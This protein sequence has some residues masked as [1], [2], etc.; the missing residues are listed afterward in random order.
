V[1]ASGLP[2]LHRYA[3][4]TSASTS[5]LPTGEAARVHLNEAWTDA[6]DAVESCV[7]THQ[8]TASVL[9]VRCALRLT[10]DCVDSAALVVPT[11]TTSGDVTPRAEAD[12]SD[13]DLDTTLIGTALTCVR[14][15]VRDVTAGACVAVSCVR[16]AKVLS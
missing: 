3:T 6:L 2:A 4:S 16:E 15:C 13:D 9:C 10:R 5:S 14:A 11:K 12:V 1:L 7:L 8:P